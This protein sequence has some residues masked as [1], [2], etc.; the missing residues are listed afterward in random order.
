MKNSVLT[1]SLCT[2]IA[3]TYNHPE[4]REQNHCFTVRRDVRLPE[5]GVVDAISVAHRGPTPEEG[6]DVF[7]VSLWQ[8]EPVAVDVPALDRLNRQL[9]VFG[10]WY[11]EFLE[12]AQCRGFTSRHRLR[13]SGN[14]VGPGVR[15]DPLLDLLSHW[16]GNVSFWTYRQ[17]ESRLEVEP[18]T[19]T[20]RSLRPARRRLTDLLEHLRWRDLEV[21]L[22]QE[23]PR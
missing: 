16:G 1:G 23:A 9:Q 12:A 17:T 2:W 20:A 21:P 11:A 4:W 10:A 3:E 15:P 5:A 22:A 14:L 8:L 13:V 19:G 7:H 6:A 18:Y